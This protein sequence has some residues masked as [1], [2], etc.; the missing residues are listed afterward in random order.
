M[1]TLQTNKWHKFE[2]WYKGHPVNGEYKL[3]VDGSLLL[4]LTGV[5][6][7]PPKD[8]TFSRRFDLGIHHWNEETYNYSIDD[9]IR[10]NYR[11]E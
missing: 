2:V 7:M 5:N 8:E 3:W 4:S 10:A 6:T 1:P 11:T 9:I